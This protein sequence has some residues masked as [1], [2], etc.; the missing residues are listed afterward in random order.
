MPISDSF[1]VRISPEEHKRVAMAA[2]ED[3]Q[4]LNS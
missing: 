4:S 2:A 3:G 1:N